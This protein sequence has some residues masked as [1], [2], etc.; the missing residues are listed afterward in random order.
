MLRYV[1]VTEFIGLGGSP[2]MRYLVEMFLNGSYEI[3]HKSN[4]EREGPFVFAQSAEGAHSSI[5]LACALGIPGISL[6][7]ENSKY[8]IQL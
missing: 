1:I 3:C 2:T 8:D 4:S 7:R 5:N 6:V